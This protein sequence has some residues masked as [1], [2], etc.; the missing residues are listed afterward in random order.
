MSAP[1]RDLTSFALWNQAELAELL[2]I[3]HRIKAG[4]LQAHQP[5][6]NKGVA[7]ILASNARLL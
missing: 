6:A 7:L 4:E 1:K 5:L 3:S 2:A